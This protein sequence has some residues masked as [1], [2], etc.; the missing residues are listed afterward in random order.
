MSSN[1]GTCKAAQCDKPVR[2]KG[3]CDRHYRQWRRGL[4]AK[5]RYNTCLEEGCRKPRARRSLCTEHFAKKH[6]KAAEAATP[7]AP[8]DSASEAAS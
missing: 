2:G 4:L 8:A 7:T 6:A 1:K 3:Y 5:P